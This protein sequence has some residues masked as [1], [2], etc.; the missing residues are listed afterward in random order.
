MGSAVGIVLIQRIGVHCGDPAI[1]ITKDWE[2]LSLVAPKQS[3]KMIDPNAPIRR[4]HGR[5]GHS[6]R[7]C[8]SKC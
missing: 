8:V 6:V 5:I 7:Q 4:R 1:L 2:N 3:A